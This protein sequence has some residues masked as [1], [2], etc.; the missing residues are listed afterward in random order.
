MSAI[1]SRESYGV[2]AAE[3]FAISTQRTVPCGADSKCSGSAALAIPP[4]WEREV[5]GLT[6]LRKKHVRIHTDTVEFNYSGKGGKRR[7]VRVQDP[8][9]VAWIQ[10]LHTQQAKWLFTDHRV[11]ATTPLDAAEVNEYL[12]QIS[13]SDLTAKE[14]RTWL[15]TAQA[16]TALYELP[17]LNSQRQRERAIAEVTRA[18]AHRLGNTP[19]VC[20]ASYVDPRLFEA[21]AEGAFSTLFS[22]YR[23]RESKWLRREDH[24]LRYA[25]SVL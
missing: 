1:L 8:P 21:F 25:L 10:Q 24:L 14:F 3:D 20:R 7:M 22:Q 12:R 9:S 23:Y 2:A 15:A 19:A 5:Y 11:S 16:V 17:A 6:T 13:S 4:A 18:V